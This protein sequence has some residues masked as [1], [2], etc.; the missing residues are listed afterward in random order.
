MKEAQIVVLWSP[1]AFA[2]PEH[3]PDDG[4]DRQPIQRVLL[5]IQGRD[6][7]DSARF[8]CRC[9]EDSEWHGNDRRA[10]VNRD[11]R[12]PTRMLHVHRHAARLPPDTC[13]DRAQPDSRGQR[14][15]QPLDGAIVTVEN[16]AQPPLFDIVGRPAAVG[17]RMHARDSRVRSVKPFDPLQREASLARKPPATRTHIQKPAKAAIALRL[18]SIAPGRCAPFRETAHHAIEL[19]P[20]VGQWTEH[21]S[22]RS[23]ALPRYVHAHQAGIVEQPVQLVRAAVDKLRTELDRHRRIAVA[24]SEHPAAD[25]LA[26][27]EDGDRNP[28]V[29][30][31]ACG[32][33][34]CR[35]GPNDDHVDLPP[36][37]GSHVYSGAH[38]SGTGRSRAAAAQPCVTSR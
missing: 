36:E 7:L 32:G 22:R 38:Q 20:E 5:L 19:L 24:V 9:L 30:Q 14:R 26:R 18:A 21:A 23:V 28:G 13:D 35:S 2:Q 16:A 37:G 25:S 33:D 10:R 17:Q 11:A 12:P 29:V 27:L 6:E 1:Y 34:P 3:N 15:R 31:R 8:T 4:A